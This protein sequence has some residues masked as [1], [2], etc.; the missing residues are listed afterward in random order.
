MRKTSDQNN[1]NQ[2]SKIV[3]EIRHKTCKSSVDGGKC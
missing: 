3:L 2:F 1:S